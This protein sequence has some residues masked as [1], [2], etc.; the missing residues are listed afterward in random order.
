[1]I[2]QRTFFE[3]YGHLHFWSRSER[4]RFSLSSIRK[5]NAAVNAGDFSLINH[6][7][8][9]EPRWGRSVFLHPWLR[10]VPQARGT[11]PPEDDIETG[12]RILL[13]GERPCEPR[14]Q[15]WDTRRR[16]RDRRKNSVGGRDSGEPCGQ[17]V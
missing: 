8:K 5:R 13:E 7:V 12:E 1:M 2:D 4:I 17:R 9:P 3:R 10:L 11:R 6:R 14:G 15:G 16:H